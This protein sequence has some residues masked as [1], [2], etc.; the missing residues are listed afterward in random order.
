[1]STAKRSNAIA[2][3]CFGI[4]PT[5]P[6]AWP[7]LTS[8]PF[9]PSHYPYATVDIIFHGL[10]ITVGIDLADEFEPVIDTMDS[11][12]GGNTLHGL[13]TDVGKDLL[14]YEAMQKLKVAA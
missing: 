9:T 8:T 10:P 2:C 14:L 5:L 7:G 12:D 4:K 6:S 3:A 13:F 11:T 1:M